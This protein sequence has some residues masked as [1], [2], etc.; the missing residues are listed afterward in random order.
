[1]SLFIILQKSSTLERVNISYVCMLHNNSKNMPK[2]YTRLIYP[3]RLEVSRGVRNVFQNVLSTLNW[4]SSPHYYFFGCPPSPEQW[5]QSLPPAAL[6]THRSLGSFP[7]SISSRPFLCG[8]KILY[9]DSNDPLWW[10]LVWVSSPLMSDSCR[11]RA[12][13]AAALLTFSS[14]CIHGSSLFQPL[15]QHI[16]LSWASPTRAK[17]SPGER[18]VTLFIYVSVLLHEIC[19]VRSRLPS[20]SG[21]GV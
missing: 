19:L 5:L 6:I 21:N 9:W 1:M 17:S 7:D 14:A 16:Q 3:Y 4:I 2:E 18:K 8:V 12:A 11:Y 13:A 15:L 20:P 10:W